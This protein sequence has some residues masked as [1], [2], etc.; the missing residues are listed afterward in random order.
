MPRLLASALAA[1]ILTAAP[2]RAAP[3]DD[4]LESLRI[5]DMLRI[6][7]DEGMDYG[8][9]LSTDMFGRPA[10]ARWED[11]VSEIYDTDR[12]REIAARYASGDQSPRMIALGDAPN[13][14]EMLETADIGVI[15]ANPHANPLPGL[16]GEKAGRIARTQKPGPEGWNK[17]V[18]RIIE[19]R[20]DS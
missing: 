18:L 14:I 16:D 12:M 15:V 17:S 10:S 7:R 4:L 11:V 9:D 5:D 1:L 6:M 20:Q 8:R 3:A 19:D 2:L 13:D